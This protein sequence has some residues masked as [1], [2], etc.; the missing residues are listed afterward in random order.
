MALDLAISGAIYWG[1][2][3]SR[4]YGS[5]TTTDDRLDLLSAEEWLNIDVESKMRQASEGTL[6]SHYSIDELVDL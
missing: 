4:F 2:I 5:F 1:F 3:D 6:I